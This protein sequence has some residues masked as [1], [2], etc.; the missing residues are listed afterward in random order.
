M[1]KIIY[2]LGIMHAY[3]CLD[4]SASV[5]TWT[6]THVQTPRVALHFPCTPALHACLAFQAVQTLP[7]PCGD[8]SRPSH[9][10]RASTFESRCNTCNI[11]LKT[12]ETLET[13]M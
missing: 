7:A 9:F 8:R 11:C 4:D 3:K 6:D 10:P 13:F 1:V 2:I 12:D 5:W